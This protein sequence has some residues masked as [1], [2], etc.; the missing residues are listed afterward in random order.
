M[1]EVEVKREVSSPPKKE[2]GSGSDRGW[3]LM[4]T[5][6]SIAALVFAGWAFTRSGE[7]LRIAG[8][9]LNVATA[10]NDKAV[11]AVKVANEA[12]EKSDKIANSEASLER[13]LSALERKVSKQQRSIQGIRA[14]VLCLERKI[15]SIWGESSSG[16]DGIIVDP[17]G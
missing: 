7:S 6:I 2:P 8:K 1:K 3:W 16:G 9:A 11:A 12:K 13:R 4:V 14:L 5:I 15:S 10:A 17:P